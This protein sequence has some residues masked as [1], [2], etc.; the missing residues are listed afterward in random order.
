[1]NTPADFVPAHAMPTT[2][3]AD[4]YVFAFL[5]GRLV[6]QG[7]DEAPQVATLADIEA[8]GTPALHYLGELAGRRV[9]AAALPADTALPEGWKARP[10]RSLFFR[11]ADPLVAL[12]GRAS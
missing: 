3:D 6:T 5:D 11:L 8:F 1:M 2:L 10:L 4:A 12:A 7:S 9:T